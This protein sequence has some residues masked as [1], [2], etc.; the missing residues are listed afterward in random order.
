M[1]YVYYGDQF[2]H[3]TYSDDRRIH[4]GKLSGDVNTYLQLEFTVPPTNPMIKSIKKRDYA[5]PVIAT[6]DDQVLFRGYVEDTQELINTELKVTCKGDLAMLCDTL[7]RPYT[8][9]QGD[10]IGGQYIGSE[11]FQ[12]LFTWFI[13]QH[14]SHVL[15]QD[16]SGQTKGQEK[17]FQIRYPS[18]SGTSLAQECA[19]L[20]DRGSTY[21][22]SSSKPNTLSEIQDKILNALGAYLQLWYDGDKKCLALYAN[23]PDILKNNQTVEFGVNM[24]DYTYEDSCLDTYTAIRPEGGTDGNN[25]TV[26]LSSIADGVVSGS[27]YKK[28]DVVYHMANAATYGYR[29]YSWSDSTAG[30][31]NTL[32]A[33]SLQQLQNIMYSSQS[34]DVSAMD[35]VFVNDEY[36]HL[37]PGWLVNVINYATDLST[38]LVVSHC[39]IDFDSPG[40]TKYSMG[41][42]ST[43][44]TKTFGEIIKDI[45]VSNEN[46]SNAQTSA[47]IANSNADKA[48]QAAEAAQRAAENATSVTVSTQNAIQTRYASMEGDFVTPGAGFTVEYAAMA[49]TG[50]LRQLHVR[51]VSD[52]VVESETEVATILEKPAIQIPLIGAEGYIDEEGRIVIEKSEATEIEFDAMFVVMKEE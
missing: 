29:E 32:L 18:G 20:D 49:A 2:I 7:V 47:G 24:T 22:Y 25:G 13:N 17:Q 40:S 21:A 28:G 6:F 12:N 44:I 30:D 14:N 23:I 52:A 4:D 42:S 5:N 11:G 3:D 1:Y 33:R 48:N 26:T 41:S 31:A 46:A 36:K 16:S 50:S 38:E 9:R 51:M 43:R 27:F 37:I 15:Y 35:M 8:N 34:V 39:D 10:N 45:E 19:I